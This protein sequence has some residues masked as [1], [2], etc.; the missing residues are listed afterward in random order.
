M[1]IL[2]TCFSFVH[3]RS[4]LLQYLKLIWKISFFFHETMENRIKCSVCRRVKFESDFIKNKKILKSC[5]ACRQKNVKENGSVPVPEANTILVPEQV[6][7][8]IPEPVPE[9]IPVSI[10]VPV[11]DAIP[12]VKPFPKQWIRCSGKWIYPGEERKRHEE[13]TKRLI[14]QFKVHSAFSVHKYLTRWILVDIR[15]HYCPSNE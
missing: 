5:I 1:T 8:E 15:D 4:I 10:P 2:Y 14:R 11:P 9:A 13:L 6:P 12:E 7:E 3:F